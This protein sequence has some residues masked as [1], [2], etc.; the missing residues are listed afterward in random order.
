M[1]AK[2]E[3]IQELGQSDLL[4]PDRIAASLTANDRAK[5]F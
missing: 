5:Y 1:V 2:R 4:L 3:I